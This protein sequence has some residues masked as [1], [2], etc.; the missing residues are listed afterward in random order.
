MLQWLYK[1]WLIKKV[2]KQFAHEGK[3]FAS[4]ANCLIC[5]KYSLSLSS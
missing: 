4:A 1:D 2:A 3:I 5:S